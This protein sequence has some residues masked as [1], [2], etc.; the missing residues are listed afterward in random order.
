MREKFLFICNDI[1]AAEQI[2]NY[3]KFNKIKNFCTILSKTAE[4]IFLKNQ[5]KIKNF[6]KKQIK[7]IEVIFTGTSW[8]NKNEIQFIKKYKSKKKIITFLDEVSNLKKRFYYEK[9]YFYP[10]EIWVPRGINFPFSKK[11]YPKKIIIKSIKNYYFHYFKKNLKKI[12]KP[13][14]FNNNYL[15]L[16]QANEKTNKFFGIET[17][18]NE[19]SFLIKFLIALNKNNR[20]FNVTIRPHPSEP[21]NKYNYLIKNFNNLNLKLSNN[22]LLIDLKK[23]F[24][25]I[26]YNSNALRLAY[27]NKNKVFSMAD[28][29]TINFFF[30]KKNVLSFRDLIKYI[31]VKKI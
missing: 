3:I 28:K 15:Y 4:K 13:K 7:F 9:K 26:G 31:K 1:G 17:K 10:D 5:I 27:L 11:I 8:R 30:G 19:K 2:S 16:T 24:N 23:N 12:K 25:V 29:K 21:K 22:S 14:L 18:K 20:N 6:N